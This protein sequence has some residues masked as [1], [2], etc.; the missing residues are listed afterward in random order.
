MTTKK[1]VL[2]GLCASIFL[3]LAIFYMPED[4]KVIKTKHFT[5]IFSASIDS[6]KIIKISKD[7]EGSYLRI[8]RN[9]KI[10]P[11]KNIETNIY[12]DKWRYIKATHRWGASGSIEGPSK[13]HFIENSLEE[14]R[15]TAIHEF[16]HTAVLK[17]L[18]DH[19]GKLFDS[20]TFDERL[21]SFPI[22]LWEAICVY[23]AGDLTDP[24]KLEDLRN[25]K[26]PSIKELNTR[27]KGQKIYK[28]GY[29][30]IEFI[31]NKYKQDKLI[32]LIKN[33]GDLKRTLGVTDEQFSKDWYGFVQ[34]KY[35]K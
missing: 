5:F 28:Y 23:E 32:E 9:L 1:K 35:L 34:E 31:L 21:A 11:S 19:E 7:L 3:L 30:L 2:I 29:T 17:L 27:S 12:A 6:L 13:I 25:G 10:I 15:K 18:I 20:K 33:Y 4:K 16:T 22:W 24:K 26:Y 14:S 8:A